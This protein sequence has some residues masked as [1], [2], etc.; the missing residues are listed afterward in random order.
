MIQGFRSQ[1]LAELWRTGRGRKVPAPLVARVLRCLDALDNAESL[2][3]L[4]A[5]GLRCHRLR[6]TTPNRYSLWV[7]GPWRVTCVWREGEG[8]DLID[9]EQ[10]H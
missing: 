4:D 5:P 3:D 6:G 1:A 2:R 8:P 9:L 7:N 10:Y